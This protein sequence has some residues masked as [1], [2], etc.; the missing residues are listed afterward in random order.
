MQSDV[1]E[2]V[3]GEVRAELARQKKSWRQLAEGVGINRESVRE[4]VRGDRPFRIEELTAIA[5]W[6]GVP[7][8]Q[9]LPA[10]AVAS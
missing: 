8:T 4:S 10:E 7:V 2:S 3:A 5:A 6:L 9:F 1:R